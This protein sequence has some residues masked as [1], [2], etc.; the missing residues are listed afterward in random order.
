MEH[1]CIVCDRVTERV[2]DVRPLPAHLCCSLRCA[3]LRDDLLPEL[4]DLGTAIAAFVRRERV[5][6]LVIQAQCAA[7][8]MASPASAY[9]YTSAKQRLEDAL[10]ELAELAMEG[11]R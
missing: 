8:V 3:A 11:K 5:R 1:T 9:A 4:I 10:A 2:S 7:Y 6:G